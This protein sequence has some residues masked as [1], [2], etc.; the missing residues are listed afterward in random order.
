MDSCWFWQSP[1]YYAEVVQGGGVASGG[2][3]A[4][5]GLGFLDIILPSVLADSAMY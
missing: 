2:L 1:A 5:Y 4:I 3:V